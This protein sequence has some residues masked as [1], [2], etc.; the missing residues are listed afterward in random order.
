MTLFEYLAVAASIVLSLSVAQLLSALRYISIRERR[1]WVHMAWVAEMLFVHVVIWWS[2]W[3]YREVEAWNFGMFGVFLLGPGFLY[4]ASDALVTHSPAEVESWEDHFISIRRWFFGAYALLI[5]AAALR[6]WVLLDGSFFAPDDL[7][8]YAYLSVG[9]STPNRR[10][11]AV[12]IVLEVIDISWVIW[13]RF[14]P[15]LG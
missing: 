11:Q 1:Y 13:L 2:M 3:P 15:G 5:G 6:R 4:V 12:V 10:V 7:F 9:A 8:A 14:L